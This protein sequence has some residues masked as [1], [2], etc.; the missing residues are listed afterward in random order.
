MN[1]TSNGGPRAARNSRRPS[2]RFQLAGPRAFTSGRSC[3]T[4]HSQ[5]PEQSTLMNPRILWMTLACG[6]LSTTLLP[7]QPPGG[8]RGQGGGPPGGGRGRTMDPAAAVEKLLSLDADGDGQLTVKEV[9]DARLTPLLQRADENQDGVITRAELTARLTA[10]AADAAAG[11]GPA[12][13]GPGAGGPRG[14]FGPDGGFRPRGGPDGGF[15][16]GGGPGGPLGESPPGGGPPGAMGGRPRPGEVLPA[17]LQDRLQLTPAQREQIAALQQHVDVQLKAIL[18]PQ[19]QTELEQA[20]ARG[21]G[22]PGEPGGFGP[23]PGG[24]RPQGGDRPAG[25]RPQ[26]PSAE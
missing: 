19:Q 5:I 10:E 17:G 16:P 3:R 26:R 18:T 6:L 7:A 13:G 25:G 20:R 14:D 23:P 4:P 21:P 11:A 24:E 22:R 12:G 9:D 15:G 1:A 2:D 8:G